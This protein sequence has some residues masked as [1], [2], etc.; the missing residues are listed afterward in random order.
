M[1]YMADKLIA[2]SANEK[3]TTWWAQCKGWAGEWE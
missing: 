1:H 3:A 2:S